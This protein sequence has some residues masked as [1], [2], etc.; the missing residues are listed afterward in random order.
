[1][2]SAILLTGWFRTS[3]RK[4]AACGSDICQVPCSAPHVSALEK[5]AATVLQP[6]YEQL[7]ETLPEQPNPGIEEAPFRRGLTKT[8][9]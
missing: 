1:M 9:L 3:R 2:L 6:V 8:W 4:V 7:A 5:Q